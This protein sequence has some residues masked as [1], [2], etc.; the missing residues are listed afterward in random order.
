MKSTAEFYH[1]KKIQEEERQAI[2]AEEEAKKK[3][4]VEFQES[5]KPIQ[6]K[7]EIPTG[8]EDV[9]GTQD[10]DSLYYLRIYGDV[11]EM[12]STELK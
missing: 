7:R 6:S 8:S 9:L 4:A 2:V 12:Y 10:E 5:G 11:I 3:A 1:L